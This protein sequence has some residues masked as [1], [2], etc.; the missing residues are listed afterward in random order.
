MNPTARFLLAMLILASAPQAFA[1]E[2]IYKSVDAQGNVTF[3]SK[4]PAGAEAVE[5]IEIPEAPSAEDTAAAD[6]RAKNIIEEA[7]RLSA[8][9]QDKEKALAEKRK[10]AAEEEERRRK[11][12]ESAE[13]EA[14][15]GSR[16]YWY[17]YPPPPVRPHPPG[18]G[19]PKPP[20]GGHPKPPEKPEPPSAVINP[21]PTG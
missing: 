21:G 4:P 20:G 10:Q 1:S 13:Q 2:A 16:E 5:R 17:Y 8:E 15:Q 14:Q 19:H 18:G 7:D 3:S 11:E 12:T 6:E 9:R